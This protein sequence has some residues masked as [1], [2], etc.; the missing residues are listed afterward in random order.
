MLLS[1]FTERTGYQPTQ[2]EY[3]EIER[4]YMHSSSDKDEFCRM[5]KRAN[6]EKAGQIQRHEK[7]QKR[8]E[9]VEKIVLKEIQT[10]K[11]TD[12]YEDTTR[13]DV[14]DII[15][16]KNI[17]ARELWLAVNEVVNI[18]YTVGLNYSQVARAR[19]LRDLVFDLVIYK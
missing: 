13:F 18:G 7:A 2:E 19:I 1:E 11:G 9:K 6:P 14:Y 4:E 10:Y 17:T 12:P 15:D 3:E 5:W 8:R 16:R